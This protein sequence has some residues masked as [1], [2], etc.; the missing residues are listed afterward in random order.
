MLIK[1]K[2]YFKE[3]EFFDYSSMDKVLLYK[4]NVLRQKINK[5]I[6]ITSSNALDGHKED[7]YH[8]KG[9]AVD[10]ICPD[11]KDN[12]SFFMMCEQVDFSGIGL[13]PNWVFLGKRIMGVHLDV[14][15]LE[16]GIGSRWI[17]VNKRNAVGNVIKSDYLALSSSNLKKHII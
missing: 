13:Y 6:L 16:N 10:I 2:N 5:K 11:L 17:C 7:S 4:L 12:L 9:E 3:K 1:V 8:Y 14:R 15:E